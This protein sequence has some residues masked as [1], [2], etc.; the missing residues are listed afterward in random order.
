MSGRDRVLRG[1]DLTEVLRRAA[2]A[3][4]PA[5]LLRALA[6]AEL[7]VP[8]RHDGPVRPPV[9]DT[10]QGPAAL[11][12]TSYAQLLRAAGGSD[13]PWHQVRAAALAGT[14]PGG[15]WLRLD[16]GAEVGAVLSPDDVA[17]VAALADGLWTWASVSVGACDRWTM[18]PGPSLPDELDLAAVLAAAAE[19]AVL[20]VLRAFRQLD[21]PDARPWRVL[22]VMVDRPVE[23][24]AALHRAVAQAAADASPEVAE[25][26][27]VD[28]TGGT[29]RGVDVL[30][31]DEAVVLWRRSD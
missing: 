2:Q 3:D 30:L 7:V 29:I 28:L 27:V 16:E 1:S 23:D 17:T 13:R 26:R 24:D 18:W 10:P 12:Y 9:V 22:A 8:R 14:W 4:S 20:Q 25:V 21:E 31:D 19:P 6:R 15:L 11:A 5:T